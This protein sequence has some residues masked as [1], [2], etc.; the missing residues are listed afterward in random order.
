M[1]L[2]NSL[3]LLLIIYMFVTPRL[4]V[5]AQ[6]KYKNEA[7]LPVVIA[8]MSDDHSIIIERVLY[9]ALRRS[10]YQM[11][12]H[13]SGMR[14][15]VADV[16]YG[17]AVIL[18]TQTDGWDRMYPNLI[19]VPVALDKVE[20]TAYAR[21]E[22]L[23]QFSRW[24]D[25]A[26]LRL[27]YRWQNEYVAN[28]V[29]RAGASS[30]VTVN[31]YTQL[32]ALL[33]NNEVDVIIL[34][35]MSH[36]EHRFPYGIRRAGIVEQQPVYTYV[37]SRHDTLAP[38][39]ENSYM[40]M[41]SDGTIS[42]I[43]NNK[44][45]SNEKPII[46]HINSYNAQNE[47]ERGLM[48]TIREK[49]DLTTENEYFN[50]YLNSNE[51]H[52]R[53][54]YNA[55]VS[56]MIRAGFVART[57]D[58]I[59][60]SG[61]EAF[62]YVLDNYYLQFPNLPVIFFGVQ[63]FDSAM[64]H[65]HEDHI[66]GV[67][68]AVSFN[69]TVSEMLRLYPKT[70]RIFILNDHSLPKSIKLSE[71]IKKSIE[72]NYSELRNLSVEFIFS[73]NKLFTEILNEIYAFGHDTLVLIG[74]YYC[75]SEGIFSEL[76]VQT[77][78][79]SASP[80]PVFNLTFS[81]IGGGTLGGFVSDDEMLS[82]KIA[83]MANDILNGK[84]FKQVP[85]V[86]D[87]ASF[88]KW[89]F[90]YEALKKFNI[91]KKSLPNG[92]I[93]INRHPH[94][95]ESNPLE[96]WLIVT[97]SA[98]VL[99]I[100]FVINYIKDLRGQK[101]YTEEL[102]LARDAAEAAN[103]IKSTF[104]ANMSHEIRTPMNS[105][106]GFAELAHHTNNPVKVKEYIGNISQS[107]DW[108][109][110]IINDILDISKIESGK[111]TLEKTPFD[112]K[113]VLLNC[114]MS[115]KTKTEEKGLS[116]YCYSEPAVEKKLIGDPVRLRQALVNLLSNAVKFTNSGAI[117]LLASLDGTDEE[118][119]F[120][121]IRFDVKDTGIGLTQEQITKVFEPFIQADDSITRRFGG[122]GLGLSITKNI[123]ELM[124]GTLKVESEIGKGTNFFFILKFKLADQ[125][126]TEEGNINEGLLDIMEK[127]NFSGEILI[128]EDNKLNQ[129]VICDHLSRVGLDTVVANNGREGVNIITERMKSNKK[130][131]ELIFMDIHMPEMDG[132]EAT[133]RI[134][135]MGVKTPVVALT[136][137]IMSNEVDLYLKKGM[138][139]C[140]GKPFASQELWKCLVK[141][142]PVAHY[143][144]AKNVWSEEE[145]K[146]SLQKA[147]LSFVRYNKNI[148][149][150]IVKA[151]K[152][153]DLKLAHRIAHNLKSNAGQI[154]EKILQ[155]SAAALE[156]KFANGEDSLKS[157]ELRNVKSELKVVLDKLEP[158]LTEF[159]AKKI[160]KI[161]DSDKIRNILSKLEIL[162]NN[163]NPEC[164]DL[165]DDIMSIPGSEELAGYIE[166]FNFKKAEVEL[167]KLKKEW[168]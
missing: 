115:I 155:H 93:I 112:L 37:N 142:L 25:M 48:E 8:A 87:S 42:F 127:P 33:L 21:S 65:G 52:S 106:I 82:E 137:N 19:K 135:D 23:S 64:L 71:N 11:V 124:E 151:S 15:A 67:P 29:R 85:I 138:S 77:L 130:P 54:N 147:R 134:I 146:K 1:P 99:L 16:N 167:S 18:P 59:I 79:A 158:L 45:V 107:A 163:K 104:L 157:D 70:K 89:K 156:S 141:F 129:H 41:F 5:L 78:C 92:H 148:Y 57:P 117:K 152:E 165:I 6:E 123:V 108:M 13:V 121:S 55:I 66:T 125:S 132:F 116:L 80:N 76:D 105:I 20:Y 73:D 149:N 96:F 114:Q 90:D 81:V 60:A 143:T 139:G 119:D 30:L 131:F 3:F 166:H 12:S 144:E 153:G 113:E 39:L 133:S 51:F 53:A 4:S 86:H 145:D 61:N 83:S 122:T 46:L 2:K 97:I 75:D 102:R 128:C 168:K 91:N 14:T 72:T 101:A 17:D 103:K 7:E 140:L 109:L 95:W 120:I 35:R 38:L 159:N 34:P 22:N 136:A 58:L 26:G 84:S 111:I 27:G 69:K 32:W 10:G 164:E 110:K 88:N 56:G 50:Y 9:T 68:Q 160:E 31:D 44:D 24:E 49:I 162:I 36:F 40:E 126:V 100:F 43:Y 98:L 154:G 47:R 94:I 74:S 161:S 62:E 63:G 28:N 118:K 150:E